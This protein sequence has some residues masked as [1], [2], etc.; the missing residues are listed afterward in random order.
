LKPSVV[1][2]QQQELLN[3]LNHAS[4]LPHLLL[5]YGAFVQLQQALLTLRCFDVVI[6]IIGLILLNCWFDFEDD[7]DDDNCA[8]NI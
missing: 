6:I 2:G 1:A 4:S 8:M 3:S 5:H 7:D